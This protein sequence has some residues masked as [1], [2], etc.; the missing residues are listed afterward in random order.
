MVA[1]AGLSTVTWRVSS[2]SAGEAIETVAKEPPDCPTVVEGLS[3]SAVGGC[4]GVNVTCACEL[5]PFHDA[6]RLTPVFAV[7]LLVGIETEAEKLPGATFTIA[8]GCA[9]VE[10]LVRLTTA[11]PPG[12][13]PFNITM[14]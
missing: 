10:S 8:G 11:P 2:V 7:T 9:T 1:T 5:T 14:A 3:V 12:A 4:C 6:V 13:W